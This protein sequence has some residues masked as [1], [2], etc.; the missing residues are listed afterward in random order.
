MLSRMSRLVLLACSGA[1]C[2]GPTLRADVI[3]Y[4]DK[5]EW[6]A[7]AGEFTTIGFT[8]YPDGTWVFEQYADLG[9]HFVD[10]FDIIRCCSFETFPVDGAGLDGNAEIHLIFDAPMYTIAADFPGGLMFELFSGGEPTYTSGPMGFGG[11][12]LFG[13][14]VS[15]EPFDEAILRD[16]GGGQVAIDDLH[17]GPPIPGPSA[18]GLIGVA[19]V[20]IV[21]RR[22]G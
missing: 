12:G 6:Q 8:E 19:F 13:G 2:V 9:V 10:G 18:L 20:G 7:G 4:T 16:W 5:A 11:V 14:I 17:F 1:C 22:R 3:E 21:R 15:S